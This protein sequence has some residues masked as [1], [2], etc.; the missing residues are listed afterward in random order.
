MANQNCLVNIRHLGRFKLSDN[1]HTELFPTVLLDGILQLPAARGGRTVLDEPLVRIVTGANV[2][3][4][5]LILVE[6]KIHFVAQ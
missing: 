6:D 4:V 2:H 1:H 3:P 5:G